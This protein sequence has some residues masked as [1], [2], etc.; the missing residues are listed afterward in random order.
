MSRYAKIPLSIQFELLI[1]V[2]LS[3]ENKHETRSGWI[4]EAIMEKL[5][6]EKTEER[7]EIK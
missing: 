5:N 1:D 4:Q 6:R 3:R 7:N 2:D